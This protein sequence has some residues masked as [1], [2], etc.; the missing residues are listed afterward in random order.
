MLMKKTYW[1][2]PLLLAACKNDKPAQSTI[3]GNDEEE[4][5]EFV[6]ERGTDNL[7]EN[8]EDTTSAKD[9]KYTDLEMPNLEGGT[10][11]LSDFVKHNKVT[12]IDCWASWCR[13]C[14][15]EMP[16]IAMLYRKYHSLGVEVVGVSF[17]SDQQAWNS[18]VKNNDMVWPQLSELNGW[19]N[20]MCQTYGVHGIPYTII[21]NQKGEII[22][23]ELKGEKLISAVAKELSK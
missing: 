14:M 18:A 10:S 7:A 6:E 4:N 16:N 21:I 1:L 12:V 19:D 23:R 8:E 9:T 17:D 11:R 2:L 20:Q 13:P 22:G 15:M 3:F 5:T